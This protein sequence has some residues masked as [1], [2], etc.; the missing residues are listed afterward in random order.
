MRK[1]RRRG[2]TVRQPVWNPRNQM[3]EV[4][5]LDKAEVLERGTTDRG[6]EYVVQRGW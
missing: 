3:Q 2:H 6:M 4:R 1:M 5:V